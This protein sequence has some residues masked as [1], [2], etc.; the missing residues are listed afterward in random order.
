MCVD[1]RVG[2]GV[3]YKALWAGVDMSMQSGLYREYLPAMAEDGRLS[4]DTLDEAVRRV[5]DSKARMGLFDDP[6]RSLDPSREAASHFSPAHEELALSAAR[7]S[8]VL[9]KNEGSVLPLKKSGQKIALIGWWVNDK[10]N[11]EG[12]GVIWGNH[13]FVVPLG[14]GVAAAMGDPETELKTVEGSLIEEPIG[15]D[16]DGGIDAA[17]AAAEWADV[18]VLALGEPK[19][20]T[21]EAQSRTDIVV[22]AAQQALAE[23]V[24]AEGKPT[25][26]LLKNG[27]ALALEGAVKDAEAIMVTWFLGKKS[28]TAIAELLF[29]DHSP[30]G[31]LPVSFP[32]RS[33]QQPYF[34]NHASSGRPCVGD[35][36]PSARGRAFKN[37]WR[38]IR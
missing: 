26:V 19:N 34:Y 4:M 16:G 32:V 35:S 8:V 29:G 11:A 12:C 27:R 3:S 13:S 1:V 18:V 21:G 20:Y 22:P 10:L 31:R 25:V 38:E 23:A 6:Y 37:C 30:E 9:L 36:P 17:K 14:E 2:V 28:G 15:G 33:G 24:A 5:L 7:K